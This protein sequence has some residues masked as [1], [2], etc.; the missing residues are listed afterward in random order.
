MSSKRI[1]ALAEIMDEDKLAKIYS[2]INNE[3]TF[4]GFRRGNMPSQKLKN[5]I[6]S[7]DEIYKEF[8]IKT[9]RSYCP[10]IHKDRLTR[11]IKYFDV[12][13]LPSSIDYFPARYAANLLKCANNPF[14]FMRVNQE[15]ALEAMEYKQYKAEKAAA[16][17]NMADE[18]NLAQNLESQAEPEL[19]SEFEQTFNS[20]PVEIPEVDEETDAVE[21]TMDEEESIYPKEAEYSNDDDMDTAE[22]EEEYAYPPIMSSY[23]LGYMQIK[24]TANNGK[25]YNFYP[26]AHIDEHGNFSPMDDTERFYY[27]PEFGNINVYSAKRYFELSRW[28]E[29]GRLYVMDLDEKLLESNYGK[30]GE[31]N[32]TKKKID[33]DVLLSDNKK[34]DS[35]DEPYCCY[36]VIDVH[37]FSNYIDEGKS[38]CEIQTHQPGIVIP[39]KAVMLRDDQNRLIGPF[40]VR[41]LISRTDGKKT[42]WVDIKAK[43]KKYILDVYTPES[44][45]ALITL[46]YY[47]GPRGEET[48]HEVVANFKKLKRSSVDFLGSEMLIKGLNRLY[49]DNSSDNSAE[50][51]IS[52]SPYLDP[53]LPEAVINERKERMLK[54]LDR[55]RG[56]K[57]MLKNFSDKI[58]KN[59]LL[60]A[61]RSGDPEWDEIFESLSQDASFM[62]AISRQRILSQAIDNKELELSQK[63]EELETLIRDTESK[64]LFYEQE[65]EMRLAESRKA[66]EERLANFRREEE[67]FNKNREMYGLANEISQLRN[68]YEEEKTKLNQ[69]LKE[70]DVVH[71]QTEALLQSFR[72]QTEGALAKIGELVLQD[73]VAKVLSTAM[74][75]DKPDDVRIPVRQNHIDRYTEL[76]ANRSESDEAMIE[77]LV[78]FFKEYRVNYSRNDILN[79]YICMTQGFLTVLSGAPGI[80]KTSACE[81]L[82]H[83]LGLDR[84][85]PGLEMPRY[86]LVPVEKG[87]SSK[88]DLIGYYNPLTKTFDKSNSMVYN[89]LE[90]SDRECADNAEMKVPPF[91]VLLDE[92]NLSQMEYYWAEFMNVADRSIKEPRINLGSGKSFRVSRSFR[93]LATINNDHTTETLSPRLIDRAWVV[94]LPSGGRYR[95]ID[96]DKDF[97]PISMEQMQRVFGVSGDVDHLHPVCDQILKDVYKLCKDSEIEVSERSKGAIQGYC[98]GASR[99]FDID[100]KNED[101]TK[102]VLAVDFAI[103]QKILPKIHGHGPAY[104]ENVLKRLE[105]YFEDNSLNKSHE[106]ISEIIRR[107]SENMNYYQFCA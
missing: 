23:Y 81:L 53:E 49:E 98:I 60:E 34:C 85:L 78:K 28:F 106:I 17:K 91:V 55:D 26:L 70:Q 62:N 75:D 24:R 65:E 21:D 19:V 105:K 54:I 44:P 67:N 56:Q 32:S 90:I 22:D 46:H 66:A 59:A 51:S 52:N 96:F 57:D 100:H 89:A 25:F 2:E 31:L 82:A 50:V 83:S 7:S 64:K 8:L 10:E 58:W 9:I 74:S 86:V 72:E 16:E 45:D 88:R 20:E 84:V 101:R 12:E 104:C 39:N 99:V 79:L 71:N 68:Q 41:D 43:D 6:N 40:N 61:V 5:E 11:N 102:E 29:N 30:N 27:F 69:A 87:W 73:K 15:M 80:G 103:A 13:E 97:D 48:G 77:R 93:F 92:A 37:D 14:D 94:T 36:Q 95:D 63:Q 3:H 76:C 38:S 47:D 33:L 42:Y 107:G 4:K 1:D 18:N 35:H